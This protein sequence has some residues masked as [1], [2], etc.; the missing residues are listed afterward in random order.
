MI[1][2]PGYSLNLKERVSQEIVTKERSLLIGN[3]LTTRVAG[4]PVKPH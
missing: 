3:Q 1:C 4:V 2:N